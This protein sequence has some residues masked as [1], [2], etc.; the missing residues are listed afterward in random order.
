MKKTFLIIAGIFLLIY[1]SG[2]FIEP[3]PETQ[4][5]RSV[6]FY[7]KEFCLKDPDSYKSVDWSDIQK[8]D[9]GYRVTHKY[10][11][12]NSFGAYVTEYKT[13]YLNDEF[14]ITNM[15]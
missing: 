9:N 7:L 10:R 2:C 11:A 12:K 14:L 4:V 3:S 13:F 8:T 1:V 5:Q 15:Y 6:R